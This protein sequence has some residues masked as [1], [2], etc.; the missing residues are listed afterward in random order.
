MTN[1]NFNEVLAEALA[2]QRRHELLNGWISADEE[3]PPAWEKVLLWYEPMNRGEDKALPE[4][5]I[6]C[7]TDD[8]TWCGDVGVKVLYWRALPEPP[9][10]ETA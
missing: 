3:T 5:G 8:G 2:K 6:G 9:K 10:E 4:Y 1:G 7:Y